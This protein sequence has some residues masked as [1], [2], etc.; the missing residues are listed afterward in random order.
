VRIPDGIELDGGTP[1]LILNGKETAGFREDEK[2]LVLS[3]EDFN[4]NLVQ[5]I[6]IR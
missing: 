1:R 2:F 3:R 4:P 6:E 5:T